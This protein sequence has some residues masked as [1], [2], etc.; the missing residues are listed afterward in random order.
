M[1]VLLIEDDAAL[2]ESLT[3]GLRAGG[4][5]VQT[6]TTALAGCVTPPR[7]LCGGA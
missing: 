4:Y 7:I 2:V 6:Q 1:R 5:A 3:W